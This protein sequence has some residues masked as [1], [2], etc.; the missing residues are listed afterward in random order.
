MP[1]FF[2]TAAGEFEPLSEPRACS[3]VDR[4]HDAVRD[5]Y[6]LVEIFPL[7]SGQRFGLGDKDIS[8]LLLST[9]HEGQT[10]FPI[11]EWP[12]HVYVARILDN[13]A[14]QTR[15]FGPSQ[16]ELIAK[17]TLYR[18]RDDAAKAVDLL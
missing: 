12:S 7:L 16:V 1:D 13:I 18:S 11:T 14:L 6:M 8:L 10:L 3:A 4:L 15:S 9:R 5:D 17:G 2:L